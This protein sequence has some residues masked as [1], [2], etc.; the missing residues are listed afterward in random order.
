MEYLKKHKELL[1]LIGILLLAAFLRL[2][3]IG[4]Y[5]TF[6]GDEGRDVL[7]VKGILEGDFTLLGPRSSAGN[8]FT[9]PI[10]YYMIAPFLW[11]SRLD[12]VGPAIMVGLLGVATVYLLYYFCKKFFN[13]QVGLIAAFLYAIAPL[14]IIYSHS[15]WNP[16]PMPF[17]TLLTA[18]ILYHA[19][20]TG[21]KKYFFIVGI[22]YGIL[23]QL[24][25]SELFMGVAIVIFMFY[26]YWNSRKDIK[27]VTV[28]IQYVT[29]FL[30]FLVGFSPFI[31]FEL[32]HEFINTKTIFE[33]I[34]HGD[35]SASDLTHRSYIQ[36]V[37][38]VF[39]RVF[40]RIVWFYP[41]VENFA[42]WNPAVLTGWY[43]AILITTF[44]SLFTLIR[45]RKKN[46]LIVS[47][48]LLWLASGVFLFGFYKKPIN[49]Y[50]FEFMFPVPFIITALFLYT[51]FHSKKGKY[52]GKVIS[53]LLFSVIVVWSLLNNPF[54]YEPNRQKLQTET[55]ADF[56]I[57]KTNNEP[58]NFALLT[59]GNSD[60]GYRYY[61][62]IKQHKPVQIDNPIADPE[63]KT[64][65]KQLLIVCEDIAC[66][67]LGN[68]LFDVAGFGRAKIT[69]SWNVSVV[70]VYRLVPYD[71]ESPVNSSQ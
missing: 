61:L 39:F 46:P 8:F 18:L 69:G 50:N 23:L 58:Y 14:V 53:V 30:G 60:H 66:K 35:P 44:A 57:S 48:L 5:M 15:S 42:K 55:I 3:R 34:L 28:G 32:R 6:L 10:Y 47:L 26:G 63:R 21:K 43:S 70:K 71:E 41:S 25:Y 16:N 36:I 29:V 13:A 51:L 52:I 67:P 62:E 37:L 22:L 38:D 45:E 11:L 54:R 12:P 17:F 65:M 19:V 20:K 1:I 24:H 64:V 4:D 33:F 68:P 2:Y 7:I 56:V 9:G 59:P 31:A 49:D 40:G 27:L